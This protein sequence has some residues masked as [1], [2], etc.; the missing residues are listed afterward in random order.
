MPMMDYAVD[1]ISSELDKKEIPTITMWNRLEGRPKTDNFER[2]LKAEVRD[3]LWMLT[4]QWQAGEFR[5]DDAGWPVFAKVHVHTTQLTKYQ[6]AGGDAEPF[7]SS[8]PLEAKVE[9]MPIRWAIDGKK[10]CLDLRMQLGRQWRKMLVHARLDKYV[11]LYLRVYPIELAPEDETGDIIYSHREAW[12]QHAAAA[13]RCIDGGELLLHLTSDASNRASDNIVKGSKIATMLNQ[14]GDEFL[15]WFASIYH[16]PGRQAAW[17]PANLEYQVACSA[18]LGKQEK[19]LS[20]DQYCDGHL[21]WYSFDHD[22]NSSGLEGMQASPLPVEDTITRS[23]IPSGVAFD[24]M[25]DTR[26]WAL[27]DR[28]TNFGDIKPS[29]TD[30]AQL[31]LIEFGLIYANDWFLLPLRVPTGSLAKVQGMV[32]TNNFGERFWINAA[33]EGIN[34]DW[35]RF[36]MF[37]LS[38]KNSRGTPADLSLFVPPAVGNLQTSRPLEQVCFVRDEVANMV[39]AVETVVPD[40]NGEGRPGKE[41]AREMAA[42]YRRLYSV[43]DDEPVAYQAS[44]AYLAATTVPENW[45][46]F[47]PVHVPGSV[48]EVQLQRSRMPRVIE[49]R[50]DLTVKIPPRTS[51]V[52]EGLDEQKPMPYFLHEDEVP[53]AGIRVTQTF[54][55]ARWTDGKAHVWLGI[56]KRVGYGEATSGLAFD[57]IVDVNKPAG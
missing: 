24:G 50:P 6:P 14:L 49:G 56:S 33:G 9:Q 23:F 40:A 21:D 57:T 54:Q 34:G 48:R 1:D 31:L 15:R 43:D 41:T 32:V 55:R 51:L 37:A 13:G 10:M 18:P 8:T 12:Q 44:I 2:A 20:A 19:V 25:P 27:E 42:F 11:P 35:S 16:Q 17:K 29:T 7:D 45:I 30:L 39:W 22:V 5:G 3:A 53:R 26:W 28:K 36:C 47:V 52:R 4:K 46:P 38:A